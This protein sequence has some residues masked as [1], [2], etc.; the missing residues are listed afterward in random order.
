M[1]RLLK[2]TAPVK[3]HAR[4]LLTYLYDRAVTAH[5]IARQAEAISGNSVC[6][7]AEAAQAKAEKRQFRRWHRYVKATLYGG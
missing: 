7:Q 1:K 4:G 5:T 2:P 3:A 6:W